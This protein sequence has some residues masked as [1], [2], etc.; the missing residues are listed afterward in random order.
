MSGQVATSAARSCGGA[1]G[2]R[3]KVRQ[4]TPVP[5][6]LADFV[7]LHP[8]V[9]LALTVLISS[10]TLYQMLDAGD[11]DLVLCKRRGEGMS[12]VRSVLA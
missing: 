7:R 11:L 1:C 5:E 12:G 6:V 8:L 3:L 9:D 4:L 2:R 10:A